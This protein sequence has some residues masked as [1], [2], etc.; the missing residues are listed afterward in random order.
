MEA[1]MIHIY[2]R[3]LYPL[4]HIIVHNC[5]LPGIT[6]EAY[7]RWP[8]LLEEEGS[9]SIPCSLSMYLCIQLYLNVCHF[10]ARRSWKLISFHTKQKQKLS[11]TIWREHWKKK[12]GI[13]GARVALL[14]LWDALWLPGSRSFSILREAIKTEILGGDHPLPRTGTPHTENENVKVYNL[15][16]SIGCLAERR[17]NSFLISGVSKESRF[18]AEKINFQQYIFA[19]NRNYRN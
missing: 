7:S 18:N 15:S 8:G 14:P 11:C 10:S 16:V 3:S 1:Y 13:L 4:V 9:L 2:S 6:F 5:Q 17:S 19:K 12:R